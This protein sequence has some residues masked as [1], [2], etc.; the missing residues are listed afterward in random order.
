MTSHVL[1]SYIGKERVHMA[2]GVASV[3]NVTCIA[4]A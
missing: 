3:T 4:A 2:V 1:V